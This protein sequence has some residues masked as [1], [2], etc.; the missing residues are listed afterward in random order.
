MGRGADD[1]P[2]VRR[3]TVAGLSRHGRLHLAPDR[4]SQCGPSRS[5]RLVNDILTRVC[6][7]T[8]APAGPIAYLLYSLTVC[9]ACSR[10]NDDEI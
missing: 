1:R 3:A 9:D 2:K 7:R 8:S 10:P 6:D 4:A 5:S